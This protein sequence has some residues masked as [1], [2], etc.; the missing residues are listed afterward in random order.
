MIGHDEVV[1]QVTLAV[2]AVLDLEAGGIAVEDRL[3][4][5]LGADSLDLLDLVFQLEQRFKLKINPRDIER[6]A[7]ERL[8]DVPYE[9]DGVYTAAA[10][11]ELRRA[12]PEVPAGELAEGLETKA[13]PRVF[14]VATF[15]SLVERMMKEEEGR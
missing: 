12:L 4:G 6:E 3:V 2:A 14:R 8:G 11:A 13:L 5:D 7:R 15:V 10:L 1:R 9:Q